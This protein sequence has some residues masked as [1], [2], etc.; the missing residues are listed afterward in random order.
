MFTEKLK[1][2]LPRKEYYTTGLNYFG[3]DNEG[4]L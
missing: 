3:T 4:N 2:S 1:L